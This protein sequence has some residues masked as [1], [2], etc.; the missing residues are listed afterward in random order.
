MTLKT[1][2]DLYGFENLEG[3]FDEESEG[4]QSEGSM[5]VR[6]EMVLQ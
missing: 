4:R 5:I 6:D 3:E 1:H 2:E